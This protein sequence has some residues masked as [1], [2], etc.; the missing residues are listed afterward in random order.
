M[1][2]L[3]MTKGLPASGKS[4][5]AKEVLAKEPGK[6]KRVNKDDLRAMLDN[7]KWSKR[8]EKFVLEMRDTIVT[9]ALLQG[10]SVIVDDTNLAPKHEEVLRGIVVQHNAVVH[11][12]SQSSLVEFEIKDFT[13]VSLEECIRRDQKRPNYVGEKVIKQMYDQFLRPTPPV[14]ERNPELPDAVVCDIDGTLALFGDANPYERDFLQDKVNQPIAE[15]LRLYQREHNEIILVSG[16]NNKFRA[17]TE[18]W[19]GKHDIIHDK[20]YMERNP[21]DIRKDYVIK[22]ETYER[23]IKDKYNVLFVLDDRNQVVDLWRNLGLTCL[24]VA[25]G[26]F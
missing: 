25:E 8:N 26:D 22:T 7:G 10:Y 14:I 19:L 2:K 3:I 16:R 6:W 23:Y 11:S 9:M 21:D 17:Q 12:H 5:W 18:E 1:N 24:Q 13:S 15:M 4:T 20:L